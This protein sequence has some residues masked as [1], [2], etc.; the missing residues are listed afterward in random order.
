MADVNGNA[1]DKHRVRLWNL[2][3]SPQQRGLV[4]NRH[5]A[6]YMDDIVPSIAIGFR[7]GARRIKIHINP[8]TERAQLF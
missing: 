4:L 3:D 1:A 8:V 7:P 2:R 5:Q 6:R